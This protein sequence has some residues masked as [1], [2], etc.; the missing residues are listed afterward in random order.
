VREILADCGLPAARLG[1][2]GEQVGLIEAEARRLRDLVEGV[3][4][5][6]RPTPRPLSRVTA[7]RLVRAVA[8]FHQTRAEHAGVRLAVAAPEGLTLVV[9]EADISRALDNLVRNALDVAPPGTAVEVVA[10]SE[11]GGVVLEVAD[12]GPGFPPEARAQVFTP[13][14]TT[15]ARGFGL[16]LCMV[17]A[18]AD[19]AGGRV[20]IRDNI[21]K[22]ARVALCLPATASEGA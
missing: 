12:Q 3:M 5:L 13:F 4:D 10:R 2:L 18:A 22:G 21:P 17:G 14:F 8:A 7:A 19:R 1:E 15:K 6:A 11:A 20:E 9:D 16:G